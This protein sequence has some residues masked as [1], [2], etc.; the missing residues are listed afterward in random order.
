M[1]IVKV[2]YTTHESYSKQN[3]ENIR[4]V[5]ESLETL[6]YRDIF[7]HVCLSADGKTFTHTAFFREDSDQRLLNELP[8]FIKFQ[9]QLKLAGFENPPKPELL[10]L[11]G[12]SKDIFTTSPLES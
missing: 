10:T 8:A 12:S 1:K 3:Q 4:Q 5:M 6:A 11:V 7:Y 9:E 2:I